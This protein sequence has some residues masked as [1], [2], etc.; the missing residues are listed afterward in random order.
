MYGTSFGQYKAKSM[1]RLPNSHINDL[2]QLQWLTSHPFLL[3]YTHVSSDILGAVSHHFVYL[4]SHP[5]FL[6]PAYNVNI[7]TV[8][9]YFHTNQSINQSTVYYV[10]PHK[11]WIRYYT[12]SKI[13]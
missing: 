10:L 7:I 6:Q 2:F 11:C 4:P 8:E 1:L 12:I 9:N 3:M 5:A 13:G